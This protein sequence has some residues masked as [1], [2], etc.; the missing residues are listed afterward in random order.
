MEARD[1]RPSQQRLRAAERTGVE[2]G[3][4]GIRGG[5][6]PIWQIPARHPVLQNIR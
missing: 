6:E 2:H 4:R 1:P 5:R 3:L